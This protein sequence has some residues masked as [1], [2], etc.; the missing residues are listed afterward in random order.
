L[1]LVRSPAR[2]P[3]SSAVS[4]SGY[5]PSVLPRNLLPIRLSRRSEP[6]D[7]DL[8][9]YELK[10]DGLRALAHVHDGQCEIDF[11]VIAPGV[12]QS[13]FKIAVQVQ[14]AQLIHATVTDRLCFG[15]QPPKK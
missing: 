9:I 5:N 15:F 10:I 6:F 3:G 7:S 14:R 13:A 1:C 4:D 8:F 11:P 2:L 12:S